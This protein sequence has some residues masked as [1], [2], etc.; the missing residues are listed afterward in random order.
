MQT[1]NRK[2]RAAAALLLASIGAAL[3]V[4]PEPAQDPCNFHSSMPLLERGTYKDH[5][6]TEGDHDNATEVAELAANVKIEIASFGCVDSS[7]R[8]YTL[9]YSDAALPRRTLAQW[10][11]FVRNA[12]DGLRYIAGRKD[13]VRETI[14]YAE[15]VAATRGSGDKRVRCADD[16]VPADGICAWSTGGGHAVEVRRTQ[17]VVQVI[18]SE[19]SSR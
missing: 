16:S 11:G 2:S 7:T 17:G 4:E 13:E 18:L 12:L 3:A 10:A 15:E 14:A 6:Y 9:T 19:S 1:R 8:T 5:I